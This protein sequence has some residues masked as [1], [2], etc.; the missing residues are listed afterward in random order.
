LDLKVESISLA[1]LPLYQLDLSLMVSDFQRQ[2]PRNST[3]SLEPQ[4]K[5]DAI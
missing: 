5:R 4:E 3:L 2:L 1:A